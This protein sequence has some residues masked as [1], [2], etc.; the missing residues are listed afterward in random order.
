MAEQ[1]PGGEKSIEMRLAEIEDKLN[2]LTGGGA[3]N[4]TEEEMRAY[5]KVST[6]L[7]AQ[8]SAAFTPDPTGPSIQPCVIGRPITRGIPRGG[9]IIPRINR[10]VC[11]CYE[12]QCGPCGFTGGQGGFGGGFGGFGM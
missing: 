3:A 5:N 9:P 2:Q 1:K 12:C 8:G 11:E 6:L 4:I 10:W 7:A